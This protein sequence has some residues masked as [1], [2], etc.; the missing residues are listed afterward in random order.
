VQQLQT[1][2]E[3]EACLCVFEVHFQKL[4]DALQALEEAVAVN[5]E[6]FRG[7]G[8]VALIIQIDVK[9]PDVFGPFFQVMLFISFIPKLYSCRYLNF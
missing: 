3:Q 4:F 6:L 8:S 5:I 9:G 1:Y 7:A 2:A